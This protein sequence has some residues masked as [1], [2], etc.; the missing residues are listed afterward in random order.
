MFT[1]STIYDGTVTFGDCIA[2]IN[3]KKSK[4]DFISLY[5]ERVANLY[6]VKYAYSFGSGRGA[7]YAILKCIGITRGDEVLIQGYTC[8]AVPKA[9]IYAGAIPVYADISIDNY[10]LTLESVKKTVT[11]QTKAVIVQH[12]YG[13][14]CEEIFD[15]YSYCKEKGIFLIED[16]AHTFATK[17][18][19]RYLG[20]IGDAAFISTDHS[21]FISTSVGGLAITDNTEIGDALS[22]FY[23]QANDLTA[24]EVSSILFQLLEGV[25][26]SN[27]YINGIVSINRYIKTAV[28]IFRCTTYRVFG[29]YYLDDY[30]NFMW[31]DYT[32]PAKLSNVQALLG[33]RQIDKLSQIVSHRQKIAAIYRKNI[34]VGMKTNEG[35]NTL[36]LIPVLVEDPYQ[37]VKKLNK[38]TEVVR[39]FNPAI[40]C[41]SENEYPLI[42]FDKN[43][44][45]NS[46]Y[47]SEH[48]V[49]LPTHMKISIKEACYVCKLLE[50]E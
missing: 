16:C 22:E 19:N 43:T 15:I 8:V 6:S 23:S 37:L 7:L 47:V 25:F 39:W 41:I 40:E 27:K 42:M 24:K 4:N 38:I 29:S 9:I 3:A 32:F 34:P 18:R 50:R 26:W 10:N 46:T 17:Y 48:I 31:P 33:I 2:A 13:I 36:L 30:D 1:Q 44:C 45:P 20:T 28:N 12:T 14:P 49:S 35:D 21:K 5:H 11:P